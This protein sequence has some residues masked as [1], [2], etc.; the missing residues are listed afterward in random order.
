MTTIAIPHNGNS[1]PDTGHP[2]PDN[3]KDLR[4]E[5]PV[6]GSVTPAN[7][8][9]FADQAGR[10]VSNKRLFFPGKMRPRNQELGPETARFPE[11]SLR[12]GA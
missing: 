12:T 8:E 6:P 2:M 4:V 5:C 3:D 11:S 7:G 10:E 9:N 1:I